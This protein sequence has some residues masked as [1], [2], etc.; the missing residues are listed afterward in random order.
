M[1]RSVAVA[2]F[3]FLVGIG[4]Q[5]ASAA[6][7]YSES[8]S[9]DITSG[10]CEGVDEGTP[11]YVPEP[12][13]H[14]DVGENVVSGSSWW[15]IPNDPLVVDCDTFGFTIPSGGTLDA[16]TLQYSVTSVA[17]DAYVSQLIYSILPSD[18]NGS[19]SKSECFASSFTTVFTNGY[20]PQYSLSPSPGQLSM[21]RTNGCSVTEQSALPLPGG[22]YFFN[23][24]KSLSYIAPVSIAWDYELTF[25]V[26]PIP[27]PSAM[28]L[29]ASALGVIGWMRRKTTV[30]VTQPSLGIRGTL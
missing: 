24:G 3:V 10:F 28:W 5:S 21:N 22:L 6:T 29:L 13:F 30:Q 25:D 1:F 19:W 8:E 14:F 27:T 12:I 20:F 18:S 15:V 11:G 23:D 9:G 7:V 2:A 16:I 17:G 4:A 26:S